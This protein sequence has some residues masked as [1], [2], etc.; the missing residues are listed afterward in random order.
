MISTIVKLVERLT[1][2]VASFTLTRAD[3]LA[4]PPYTPGAHI[5]VRLPNEMV[6]SYSITN[7]EQETDCYR[8]CVKNDPKS[9]GASRWIHEHV[10]EGDRLDISLPA[11]HFPLIEDA[12]RSVF[13]AGGIG[14]T[15][16]RSMISRMQRLGHAWD[17]Y[18][19][20]RSSAT[21][22]FVDEFATF[23]SSGIENRVHFWFSDEE[24]AELDIASLIDENADT[25]YYCCGP[26]PMLDAFVKACKALPPTRVH[27]ERFGA[28]QAAT[29]GGFTVELARCGKR[30]EVPPGQTILEVVRNAGIDASF[31]CAEGV[32]GTC[33]T[34]VLGGRPDHRDAILSEREKAANDRMMICCS[35]SLDSLLVLD[36]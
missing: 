22:A 25:H 30:L 3:S 14:I 7:T 19:C 20:A 23:N 15:P 33:E 12:R 21:A 17:L 6:R 8:I 27:L 36:I 26:A 4:L 16:L 10:H 5:D 32:C 29:P 1:V 28:A 34:A 11:N 13:I 24:K 31:S 9:R 2:D 18:Y 35:G